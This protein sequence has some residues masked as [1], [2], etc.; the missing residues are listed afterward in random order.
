MK[1]Y[2]DLLQPYHWLD[3]Y[4]LEKFRGPAIKIVISFL[5]SFFSTY[6]FGQVFKQT[7]SSDTTVSA[8][9][10]L[11]NPSPNQFNLIEVDSGMIGD[12]HNESLQFVR[13]S[14]NGGVGV[15]AR[16]TSLIDSPSFICFKFK[17]D[18]SNI[19]STANSAGLLLI[20]NDFTANNQIEPNANIHSKIGIDLIDSDSFAFRDERTNQAGANSYSG[21]Q[22]IY[23]FVNNSGV[24]QTYIAPDGTAEGVPNNGWDLWVGTTRELNDRT[25]QTSNR[26]LYNFKFIFDKGDAQLSFDEIAVYD[27]L[28]AN[29]SITPQSIIDTLP[30]YE[31]YFST[32]A[33]VEVGISDSARMA[34][35]NPEIVREFIFLSSGINPSE[36][37]YNF[38]NPDA[39]LSASLKWPGADICLVITGTPAWNRQSGYGSSTNIPPADYVKYSR[40]ITDI[41][42]HYK[43]LYPRLRY[44]GAWN[45][46]DVIRTGMTKNISEEEYTLVFEAFSKAVD[47]VNVTLGTGDIRLE[48]GGPNVS[49]S[50]TRKAY[51]WNLINYCKLNNLTIDFIDVHSYGFLANPKQIRKNV[52]EI[53]DS[54]SINGFGTTYSMHSEYGTIAAGSDMNPSNSLLLRQMAWISQVDKFFTDTPAI[55]V[56]IHW[57]IRHSSNFVKNI[58]ATDSTGQIV[59]GK[60]YPYY[61]Y[62]KAR[63]MMA[64]TIIA[65]CSDRLNSEGVGVSSLIS[66]DET[67]I[68]A[69]V[70]NYQ[71]NRSANYRV[72]LAFETLPQILQTNNVKV[73]VYL[74]DDEHSNYLA[75]PTSDKLSLLTSLHFPQDTKHYDFATRMKPNSI[76]LIIFSPE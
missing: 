61:N 28:T 21:T 26:N 66:K 58:L 52:D 39:Q 70:T 20:G 9:F 6:L 51:T 69:L 3:G 54:L 18:I 72:R 59:D 4:R 31:K 55:E 7:F 29:I 30:R 32:S 24:Y 76:M 43:A 13:N 2:R 10:D 25:A 48:V 38:T 73:D 46:P 75:N 8:Y 50:Q 40:T 23:W 63:S 56:P 47:S 35:L 17:I 71:G 15:Y 19:N 64:D 41:L 44:I 49:S 36:G 27:Q 22:T 45:E 37:E 34:D 68:T 33:T 67:K 1:F 16:T 53:R 65:S 11:T 5:F 74:I 12:I 57:Q 60:V 62:L 14:I 42:F